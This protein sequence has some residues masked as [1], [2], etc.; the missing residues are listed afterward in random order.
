MASAKPGIFAVG[1]EQRAIRIASSLTGAKK[2]RLSFS[3]R[4]VS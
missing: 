4:Q 3:L 1:K 2:I